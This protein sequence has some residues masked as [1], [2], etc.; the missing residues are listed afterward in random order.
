[1]KIRTVELLSDA[2]SEEIIWRKKELTAL[3]LLVESKS[4]ATDRHNALLRG[5]VALL[6]AHWEGFVKAAGRA[7]ME[8][9]H[10]QR[11][12][13]VELSRNFIALGAKALLSRAA[14][15][16]KIGAHIEVTDFFM[17]HLHER[18]VLPYKEGIHTGH[19]LN[20]R[21]LRDITDSLG[22]DYTEFATKEVLLDE[23]LL[24]RRNTIA[25]GEYLL[26]TV[27]DYLEIHEQVLD[28]IEAFRIQVENA[29]ALKRYLASPPPAA[30]AA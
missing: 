13:F 5:A 25:H 18:C 23:M 22:L 7:Y 17:H 19:N 6:Y 29:A 21:I 26:T 3:R 20:S 16:S 27:A 28:M 24:K 4:L 11:L 1:M 12:T 30:T 9:V 14:N 2:L 15:T 8:F 10:F